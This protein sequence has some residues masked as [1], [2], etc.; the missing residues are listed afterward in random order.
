MIC[1]IKGGF[2]RN[3][4]MK[5][6]NKILKLAAL[7]VIVLLLILGVLFYAFAGYLVKI[8]IETAATKE[9]EVGVEVDDIDI[10][11]LKSFIRIEGLTVKNPAG[12]TYENFLEMSKCKVQ[13][14]LDF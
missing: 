9:L 6:V 13:I 8:G 5:A 4:I 7:L 12:Y 1:E 11:I 2:E 14:N 10:S 3:R